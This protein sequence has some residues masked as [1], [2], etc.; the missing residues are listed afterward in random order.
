MRNEKLVEILSKAKTI[1]NHVGKITI[2]L[3]AL[4]CGF[5]A[6]EYYYKSKE[7]TTQKLPMDL[8]TIHKLDGTSVAIN[9][10]NELLVIDRKQG[11]YEIYSDSVGK[12]IF[13]LYASQ[14]T[15]N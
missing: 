9:E 4:I 5:I 6:G 8:K 1:F 3:I 11:S 12:V 14:M 10:R 2:V 13:K 7:V 15:S